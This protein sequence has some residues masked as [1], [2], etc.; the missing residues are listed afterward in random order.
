MRH[1]TENLASQPIRNLV[2]NPYVLNSTG[3]SYNGTHCPGTSSVIAGAPMGGNIARRT[4]NAAVTPAASADQFVLQNSLFTDGLGNGTFVAVPGKVYTFSAYVRTST[5]R[6]FRMTA[7]WFNPSF[8]SAAGTEF[9]LPANTWVRMYHT[10]TAPAGVMFGRMDVDAAGAPTA[11]NIGD[12]L[13]VANMM[14]TEGSTLWPYF[15]GNREGSWWLGSEGGS[16]SA[17]YPWYLR[18]NYINRFRADG[19]DMVVTHNSQ[20]PSATITNVADGPPGTNIQRSIDIDV[21]AATR[22]WSIVQMTHNV[23]IMKGEVWTLSFWVKTISNPSGDAFA[24]GL[25]KSD[26]SNAVFSEN[27]VSFPVG[28][29]TR[30]V[31][32]FTAALDAAYTI[33]DSTNNNNSIQISRYISPSAEFRMLITGFSLEPGDQ[34]ANGYSAPLA[35]DAISHL[36]TNSSADTIYDGGSPGDLVDTYLDGGR[37]Y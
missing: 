37:I 25:R 32:V 8:L 7:S 1:L 13:D 33:P 35:L 22:T 9:A 16:M 31:K 28:V 4:I 18:R 29:W 14:V 3:I 26:S 30:Y 15:D 11:W 24:V 20:A 34:S 36:Y 19:P 27:G 10:A 17:I 23:K 21:P 12:T 6:T 2:Q 5:A